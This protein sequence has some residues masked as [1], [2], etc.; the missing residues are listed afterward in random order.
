MC[1]TVP[2]ISGTLILSSIDPDNPSVIV[3][4]KAPVN[5]TA[6]GKSGASKPTGIVAT[7]KASEPSIV[8]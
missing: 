2:E 8:F 7:R 1:M 6:V 5:P 3:A 4:T